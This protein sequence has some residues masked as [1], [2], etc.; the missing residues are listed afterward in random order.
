MSLLVAFRA[1]RQA[2]AA[3][4]AEARARREA[5]DRYLA[6]LDSFIDTAEDYADLLGTTYG[7]VAHLMLSALDDA[8]TD[9]DVPMT[10]S[11]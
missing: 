4:R 11:A 1:A 6:A 3:R 5:R 8:L 7:E 2:R 9:I 10:G